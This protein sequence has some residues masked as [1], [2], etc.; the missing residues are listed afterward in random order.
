MTPPEPFRE[1]DQRQFRNVVQESDTPNLIYL[2]DEDANLCQ[3][4]DPI[5]SKLCNDLNGINCYVLDV[6]KNKDLTFELNVTQAPSFVYFHKG[7]E[8]RRMTNIDYDDNV[9]AR[10]EIFLTGDFLF[11]DSDFNRLEE[12][13]FFKALK[14]WHQYNLVAF[15]QPTDPINWQLAPAL[16]EIYQADPNFFRLHLVDSAKNESLLSHYKLKNLP[17]VIFFEES[18]ELRRWHP[19]S[20]PDKIRRECEEFVENERSDQASK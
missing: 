7:E 12:M 9:E 19:A 14:D 13:N 2:Y 3:L 18:D 8:I 16:I 20:S 15:M 5:V 6:N 4:I 17:A 11:N 10:L 1:L